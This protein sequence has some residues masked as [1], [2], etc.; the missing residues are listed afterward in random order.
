MLPIFLPISIP[1]WYDW[2]VG[3]LGEVAFRIQISIPKWYDWSL[4]S[5]GSYV[6]LVIFQFLNGTIGVSH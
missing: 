5:F 4:I 6:P 2:S 3:L 1:K